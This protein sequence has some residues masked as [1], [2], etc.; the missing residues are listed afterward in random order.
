MSGL[1]T[2]EILVSGVI[3][4]GTDIPVPMEAKFNVSFVIKIFLQ[5]SREGVKQ[6]ALGLSC[7]AVSTV[8]SAR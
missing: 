2:F 4:G 1:A 5:G 8:V 7:S 6:G 3:S